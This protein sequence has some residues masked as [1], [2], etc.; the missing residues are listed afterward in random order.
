MSVISDHVFPGTALRQ[1][2]RTERILIRAAVFVGNRL[3]NIAHGLQN[4]KLR[5]SD[6]VGD[7]LSKKRERQQGYGNKKSQNL[8][9]ANLDMKF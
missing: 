3:G 4:V 6:F 7:I 8:H 1:A 9:L 2:D 5:R